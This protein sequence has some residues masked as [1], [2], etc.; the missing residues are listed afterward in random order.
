MSKEGG[1]GVGMRR[2]VKEC[3][4]LSYAVLILDCVPCLR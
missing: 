2:G 1:E 3:V 4:S